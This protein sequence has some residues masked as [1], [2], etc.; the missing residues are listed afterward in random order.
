V[1]TSAQTHYTSPKIIPTKTL[2]EGQVG[3]NRWL[4]GFKV[5]SGDIG[6]S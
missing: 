5:W 6:D 4:G 3:S 1:E 2:R